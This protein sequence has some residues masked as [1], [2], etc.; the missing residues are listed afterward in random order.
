MKVYINCCEQTEEEINFKR[1]DVKKFFFYQSS[2]FESG[3]HRTGEFKE[4]KPHNGQIFVLLTILFL[5]PPTV[6]G[7]E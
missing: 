2:D 4:S 1:R 7:T 5:M 3:I 6:P